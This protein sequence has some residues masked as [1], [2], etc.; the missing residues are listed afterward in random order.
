MFPENDGAYSKLKGETFRI[1]GP[2]RPNRFAS[3]GPKRVL[4]LA[5]GPTV[6]LRGGGSNPHT[7]QIFEKMSE[8][9]RAL[10]IFCS[11]GSSRSRLKGGV[12]TNQLDCYLT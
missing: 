10:V 3:K 1:R 2:R 4:A 12:P 9:E 6:V 11:S 7:I 8:N 5:A